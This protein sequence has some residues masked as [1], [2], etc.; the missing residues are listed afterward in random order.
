MFKRCLV[1][2]VGRQR[3]YSKVGAPWGGRLVGGL[4]IWFHIFILEGKIHLFEKF[5]YLIKILYPLKDVF[6]QCLDTS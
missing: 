2:E 5:K 3:G 1:A 6:K 4:S